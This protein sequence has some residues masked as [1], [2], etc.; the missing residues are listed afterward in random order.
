MRADRLLT[1]VLLAAQVSLPIPASGQ[2]WTSFRGPRFDGSIEATLP[3]G[4]GQLELRLAFK[5]PLGA[6]YS[7]ISLEDGI[8]VASFGAEGRDW[9]AAFDAESGRELWRHDMA[10]LFVGRNGVHDGPASTPAIAGDRVFALDP[11]GSLFALDL[12]SGLLRWSKRL[13]E[14]PG[15]PDSWYA[16][17]SPLVIGD[18]LVLQLGGDGGVIALDVRNGELR[19]HT[20]LTS[21]ECASPV[22]APIGDQRVILALGRLRLVA[23]RPSDGSVSFEYEHL[24]VADPNASP[25]PLSLDGRET[26]DAILIRQRDG[27]TN[28]LALDQE[29]GVFSTGV[30]Q[31]IRALTRTYAPP[32]H[33]Q[34]T[35]YGYTSR[36]LSAAD[37]V[38]GNELWRSRAP[39]DGW[40]IVVNGQ[41][42]VLTK[43]GSLHTGPASRGGWVETGRLELFEDLAWTPPVFGHGGIF[44]R[45]QGEIA[46][47]DLV[48]RRPLVTAVEDD[49]LPPALAAVAAKTRRGEEASVVLDELLAGKVLPLID[50]NE[51]LFLWRGEANDVG[52]GGDMLGIKHEEPMSRLPGTDLWWWQ[53]RLDP[54]ARIAYNFIVDYRTIVDPQNPRRVHSAL[55]G[56]DLNWLNDHRNEPLLERSW[57]SMPRGPTEPEYLD[58]PP[59]DVARGRVEIHT[60]EMTPAFTPGETS[61]VPQSIAVKVWLPPG[62]DEGEDRYPVAFIHT[63]LAAEVGLWPN[64]LDN[65]VGDT[66][67]PLVVVMIEAPFFL[68]QV[69]PGEF[70]A[71]VLPLIEE[72]YRLTVDRRLR[73]HIGMGLEVFPAA[74]LAFSQ[75]ESFGLLAIQSLQTTDFEMDGIREALQSVDVEATPFRVYHDWG[76]WDTRSPLDGFDKRE[77]GLEMNALLSAHG[78]E[79]VGGKVFDSTDWLS[80]RSRIDTLLL[81]LF[82][83]LESREDR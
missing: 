43:E 44:A 52:I 41:L 1:V 77:R 34:G 68:W 53:T 59:E 75:P 8:A 3:A 62:Y 36:F 10:P 65:L 40:L 76:E 32:T 71:E 61:P 28:S 33:W 63:P 31:E 45:S 18:T 78:I 20:T 70:T 51:V 2:S 4:E 26:A 57:F 46:R 39:G 25:M 29:G 37:P 73:A 6:G 38:M 47:V 30:A 21:R 23:I 80:W 24:G 9:V 56:R 74:F 14:R 67:R 13:A 22:S 64:A 49:D 54:R 27:R 17:S 83:P 19:W 35:V 42:V 5:R 50:G 69:Y 55:L 79:P 66:V 16:C 48:R 58:T 15:V 72:R 81:A 60:V 12:E 82:P 7:G 11:S